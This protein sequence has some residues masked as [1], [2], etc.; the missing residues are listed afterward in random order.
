[1]ALASS[2][3]T[4]LVVAQFDHEIRAFMRRTGDRWDELRHR[5][6]T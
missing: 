1:M 4:A 3:P 6:Y 2:T 5:P